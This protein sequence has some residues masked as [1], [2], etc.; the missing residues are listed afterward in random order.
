MIK[1]LYRRMSLAQIASSTTVTFC[2]LVDSFVIGRLLS[3]TA[4]GAYG[5]ASAVL[6]IFAAF[7]WSAACRS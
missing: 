4:L 3:P 5:L 6:N 2:L 1:K 7:G